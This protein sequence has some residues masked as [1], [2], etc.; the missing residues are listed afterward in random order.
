MV[1]VISCPRSMPKSVKH[2]DQRGSY[3]MAK[4]TECSQW[5]GVRL[6]LSAYPVRP[7]PWGDKPCGLAVGLPLRKANKEKR[8]NDTPMNETGGD[9][10]DHRTSYRNSIPKATGL[11]PQL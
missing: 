3:G 11:L 2:Q 6:P 1:K 4:V 9:D 5:L 7:K 10:N 8:R